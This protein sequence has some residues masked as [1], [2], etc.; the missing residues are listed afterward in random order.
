MLFIFVFTNLA[1]EK[2]KPISRIL[3]SRH[4]RDSY[5]LSRLQITL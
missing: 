1:K 3:L 5:H 2:S 4:G